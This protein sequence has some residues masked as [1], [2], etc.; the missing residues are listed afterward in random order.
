MMSP[1]EAERFAALGVRRADISIYSHQPGTHDAI[2]LVPGSLERSLAACRALVACGIAVRI[3][4]SVMRQNAEHCDAI[5]KLAAELGAEVQFDAKITPCLSGDCAPL[6]LNISHAAL[7]RVLAEVGP[8]ID[9]HQK[10]DFDPG[11]EHPC[12]AGVSSCYI[13]PSGDVM[14]CVEYP[15]VCGNLRNQSFSEIWS[16]SS[17]FA[18]I[19]AVRNRDLPVC[20]GCPNRPVCARCP[21]LAY[22]EGDPLGPST[23]DCRTAFARTGVPS[24]VMTPPA[25]SITPVMS[26]ESASAPEDLTQ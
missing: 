10:E 19:R 25:V 22:I 23:L 20:S 3:S 16:G 8:V 24:P 26:P 2:T 11:D 6:A 13:S 9:P 7:S 1:G 18:A 17:V 5:R 15:L 4:V 14:P 21:G 12:G